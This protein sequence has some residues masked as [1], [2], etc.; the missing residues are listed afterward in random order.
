VYGTFGFGRA[1]PAGVSVPPAGAVAPAARTV[2][3]LGLT[4]KVSLAG[5][6]EEGKL[7]YWSESTASVVRFPDAVDYRISAVFG[8]RQSQ[9]KA[10]Q[11]S[12]G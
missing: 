6:E 5:G 12:R 1:P 7:N 4:W 2:V 11:R 3:G 9:A 10:V 8:L